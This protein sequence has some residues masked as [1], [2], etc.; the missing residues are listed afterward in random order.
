[1]LKKIILILGVFLSNYVAFAQEM[2]ITGTVLD[3][4]SKEPVVSAIIQFNGEKK[5][6]TDLDGKFSFKAQSP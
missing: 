3:S 1:M 2:T 5:A 4:S 6:Q